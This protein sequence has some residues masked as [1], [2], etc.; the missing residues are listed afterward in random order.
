MINQ[1]I[2]INE[3]LHLITMGQAFSM[4]YVYSQ[5]EKQG[6]IRLIENGV[7]GLYY[8]KFNEK[9]TQ[10]KRTHFQNDTIPVID[11]AEDK[12]ITIVKSHIIMYN[13]KKVI[14]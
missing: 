12:Q 11:L 4:Q 13:N 6:Q 5:G 7:H 14:F 8:K 9:T 2:H 1:K 3:V 10:L